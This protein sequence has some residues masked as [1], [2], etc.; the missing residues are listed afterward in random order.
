MPKNIRTDKWRLASGVAQKHLCNTVALYR[1]YVRLLIG[2]VWTHWPAISAAE[3]QCAAVERLIH[4][5]KQNGKPRYGVFDR[6]FRKFPSYL[7]RAAIEAACGQVSS[8][9]TRYAKWQSGRRKRR[10]EKPPQR[11]NENA[12]NPPLYRGQCVKF[13]E[14]CTVADIKIWNGKDWVWIPVPIVGKRKRHKAPENKAQSPTLLVKGARAYLAVPFESF[15]K[16]P[17]PKKVRRVCALDLGINTTATASIVAQDGTVVARAFFHLA[18]DIDRRD[19]GLAQIRHKARQ[20][21]GKTGKLSEGFCKDAYRKATNRN[22]DM[23]NRLSGQIIAFAQA[24]GVEAIV[25]EHMKH[26]RPK[27]GKR[28]SSLRQ[29]FHGWLRRKLAKKVNERADE[30]G[31]RTEYINPAGTS[32]Y[33]Y[34]GSGEVKRDKNNRAL[35]TFANGKRYNA[36]LNASYNIGARFFAR[37][38]GLS[39]GNGKAGA[40]G[41]SSRAIQPRVPVTLSTLWLHAQSGH[42]WEGKEAATTAPQGA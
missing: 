20:T 38:L 10:D 34:D 22:R 28:R 6:R 32:K 13:N 29:R 15:I 24:H 36:D 37:V 16:L 12:L 23:A 42:A 9:V 8:F 31:L 2:V 3:S 5:T 18:A 39:A 27:G 17:S 11:T 14:S 41:K 7:R 26:F 25:F 30:V 19:R 21:M 1:D 35:A 4:A 33:A 40:A